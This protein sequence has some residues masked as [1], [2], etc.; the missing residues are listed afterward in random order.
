[1][2]CLCLVWELEKFHYYLDGSVF[3]VITDSNAIKSLLNMRTPKRH[4]LIWQNAIQEYRYNMTIVHKAGNIHKSSDVLIRW[5][6]SNTPDNPVYM[7][8]EAEEQI[9]IE[10]IQITHNGTEFF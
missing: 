6:L 9:S 4:T 5:A 3:E 1:M 7:P 2:E 10:G 8:L